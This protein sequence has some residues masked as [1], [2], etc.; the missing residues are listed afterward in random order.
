M[1][2]T[3]YLK[4]E[5][6]NTFE[7]DKKNIFGYCFY[8]DVWSKD[9]GK[10]K[11]RVVRSALSPEFLAKQDCYA[12]FNHDKTKVLARSNRGKGSLKL[13]VDSKGFFYEFKLKNT[14][15]HNECLQFIEADELNESSYGFCIA[16]GMDTWEKSTDPS[17]D[18][19]MRTINSFL[20]LNDVSLVWNGA[21]TNT[22][23]S[24]RFYN[25]NI[26]PTFEKKTEYSSDIKMKELEIEQLTKQYRQIITKEA[27]EWAEYYLKLEDSCYRPN[28]KMDW[29]KRYNKGLELAKGYIN[30]KM[31]EFEEKT[32]S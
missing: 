27:N 5:R 29:V 2:T 30:K 6:L 24:T 12:L 20:L 32:N 8:W 15:L 19:Y 17:F 22:V 13:G 3:T 25:E 7:H 9:L 26:A 14:Q 16:E 28:E 4:E 11:E 23:A 31:K 21:N 10:F 1:A 18:G